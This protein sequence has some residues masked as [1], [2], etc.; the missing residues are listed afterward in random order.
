MTNLINHRTHKGIS[1]IET[2]SSI[3]LFSLVM[4]LSLIALKKLGYSI[5]DRLNHDNRVTQLETLTNR[6]SYKNPSI[7]TPQLLNQQHP[8]H[9]RKQPRQPRQP[10]TISTAT[11]A[12]WTHELPLHNHSITINNHSYHYLD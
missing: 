3:I 5:Q 6:L 9:N 1:I 8:K 11:S 2:V 4:S 12:P 7:Q 10:T